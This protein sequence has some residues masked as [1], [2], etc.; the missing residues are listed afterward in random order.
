MDYCPGGDML[1]LIKVKGTLEE[2]VVR[3]YAAEIVLA[4]D[5]L[6]KA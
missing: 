2:E 3:K 6:H 4:I 1:K 5:A